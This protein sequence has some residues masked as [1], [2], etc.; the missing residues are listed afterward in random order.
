MKEII[1]GV[2][3]IYFKKMREPKLEELNIKT[4]SLLSEK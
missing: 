2:L 1:S 4:S 3:D